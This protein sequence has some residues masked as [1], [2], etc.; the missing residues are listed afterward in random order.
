MSE[1]IEM[2]VAAYV[3]GRNRRALIELAAQRRR[4]LSDLQVITVINPTIAVEAMQADIAMIE[5]GL[6]QLKAPPGSLPENE[7]G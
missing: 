7:W 3:K 6:E 4:L 1:A 5:A 2:I